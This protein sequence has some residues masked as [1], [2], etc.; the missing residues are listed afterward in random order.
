MA[1]A[2][3]P[4]R[5]ALADTS[6]FIAREQ[7]RP[8]AGSPPDRLR[9]SVITIAELRVGVLTAADPDTRATRLETLTRA[10]ELEPLTIDSDVSSAWAT[11][12]VALRDVGRRMPIN[13]SWI[14]ATAIAHDLPVVAQDTDYDDVPGLRVLRL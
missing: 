2:P 10:S 11:L 8:L 5:T 9:V 14:A 3:R 13:D 12:R 6:L 7:E 1:G 4:M